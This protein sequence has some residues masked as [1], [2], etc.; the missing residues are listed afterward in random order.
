M[1]ASRK[2]LDGQGRFERFSESD[3]DVSISS[4]QNV[5]I[6]FPA[7][8]EYSSTLL[9]LNSGVNKINKVNFLYSFL[10]NGYTTMS[11]SSSASASAAAAASANAG[12][13]DDGDDAARR[14]LEGAI[15]GRYPVMSPFKIC[16]ACSDYCS[17]R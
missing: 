12:P 11:A 10:L 7:A 4:S 9:V 14:N 17:L 13:G 8:D 16:L 6:K 1:S 2:G 3:L 5:E 15:Q